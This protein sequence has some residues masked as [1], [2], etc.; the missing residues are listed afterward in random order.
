MEQARLCTDC[1]MENWLGSSKTTY[2]VGWM[3]WICYSRALERRYLGPDRRSR[4]EKFSDVW[5]IIPFA[6]WQQHRLH[7][8]EKGDGAA[9]RL[10]T[11]RFL[12]RQQKL[13]KSVELYC[14]RKIIQ[15]SYSIIS[16]DLCQSWCQWIRW[17]VRLLTSD[18]L[19]IGCRLRQIKVRTARVQNLEWFSHTALFY[20][21]FVLHR[22]QTIGDKSD[23]ETVCGISNI[24]N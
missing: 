21:P 12:T 13:S 5:W 11:T 7:S 1:P 24:F 15:C 9:S 2:R 18:L 20:T 10:I 14:S 16:C 23:T 17:R 19:S 3:I 4:S 22:N 6:A 8:W